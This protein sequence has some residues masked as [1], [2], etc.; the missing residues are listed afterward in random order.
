MSFLLRFDF[1][2]QLIEPLYKKGI[3]SD[4]TRLFC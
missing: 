4:N 2:R 1:G 3:L